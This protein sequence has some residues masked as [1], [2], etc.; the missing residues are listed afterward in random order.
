[1]SIISHLRGAAFGTHIADQTALVA[2]PL[3]A[4]V[5]FEAT[6]EIIGILVACQASAH[7][8]GS[9]PMGLLVDRGHL[10]ALAIASALI[11]LV[12]FG[13]ATISVFLGLLPLFGIAIALSGLGVVLFGLTSLSVV[14]RVS[15]ATTLMRANAALELPR[16]I[17][18]FLVPLIIGL[19]FAV[20]PPWGVLA[21]AMSGSALACVFTRKLPA[22][23]VT[24]KT[25]DPIL[26]QI[27]AGSAFLIRHPLL[28]PI[29]LCALFW[30]LAFAALLVVLMPA[31]QNVWMIHPGA[32]AIALSAFGLGA[33]LGSWMSR[34]VSH[35][36]PPST[37]LLFGPA[38]SVLAVGGL[39]FLDTNS[40]AGW[41]Y[42]CFLLLGFGPFMWLLAQNSVR[43]I[44]SP[45]DM[46][47]RVNAV[48]QT[49]IYG[50]RPLG[51][52]VGGFVATEYGP[53]WGIVLVAVLFLLSFL[54][55]AFSGLRQ[56]QSY[57]TLASEYT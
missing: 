32:F 49:A 51:A 17:S 4:A 28:R 31:I 21:I 34:P 18:S 19:F 5:A 56:I 38:S 3:V 50:A 13:G 8:L 10:R 37:V 54:A 36:L 33:I 52:L 27:R 43:Q 24:L 11:S 39:L 16:A 7:L 45:P 48:V 23:D 41:L 30:N 53:Q 35:L 1:M 6:P 57:E 46:L 55:A 29:A 42:L 20:L 12:G 14:P 47:G 22:F 26:R 9:I 25:R 44:A 15:I 2:V 40:N